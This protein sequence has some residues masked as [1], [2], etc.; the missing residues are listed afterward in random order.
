MAQLPKDEDRTLAQRFII[1]HYSGN[2]RYSP[3][4][5]KVAGYRSPE[6]R[7]KIGIVIDE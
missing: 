7:E 2:L 4:E 6:T 1:L 5:E 3:E